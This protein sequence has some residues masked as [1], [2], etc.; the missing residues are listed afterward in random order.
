MGLSCLPGSI[1]IFLSCSGISLGL[2]LRQAVSFS[3]FKNSIGAPQ[4]SSESVALPV[5]TVKLGK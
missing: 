2:L 1:C 4:L 5:G 3:L